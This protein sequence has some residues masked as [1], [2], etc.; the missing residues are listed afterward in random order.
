MFL[1]ENL[2]V[3][4]LGK[5]ILNLEIKKTKANEGIMYPISIKVV[6]MTRDY[7]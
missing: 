6:R 7:E 2:Y 5:T 1:N 4:V 3:F